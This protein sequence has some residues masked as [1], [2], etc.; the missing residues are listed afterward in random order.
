VQH[1]VAFRKR[2][3]E[4]RRE[5]RANASCIALLL[6]DKVAELSHLEYRVNAQPSPR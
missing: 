5:Q 6:N 1:E 3:D 4:K 2:K